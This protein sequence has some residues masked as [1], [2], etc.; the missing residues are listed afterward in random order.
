M[1]VSLSTSLPLPGRLKHLAGGLVTLAPAYRYDRCIFLIGHMRCGS[2]A[3]ANVLCAHPSISGYGE[4]HVRYDGRAAP[5]VLLLNQIR[6]QRW[7]PTARFLFDKLLHDDL[8]A[9]VPPEFFSA[10]AIFLSR[11]PERSVPSI[12]RLF[13]AIGSAEYATEAQAAAY[14]ARRL[15]RMRALFQRFPATRRIALD[16]DRLVADPAAELRRL[17]M[18]LGLSPDISNAYPP[19]RTAVARGAGDPLGAPHFDSIATSGATARAS[20]VSDC[21]FAPARRARAA[22][23]ATTVEADAACPR[24]RETVA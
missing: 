13:R 14:Y 24:E 18:F 17:T 19:H 20:T 6:R 15:E 23:L 22:F 7:K 21:D 4:S 8:D 12:L 1:T 9:A 3:L 5:G 16:C 10:H 2:T 11:G